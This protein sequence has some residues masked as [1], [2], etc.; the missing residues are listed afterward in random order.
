MNHLDS[1]NFE[2]R[3]MSKEELDVAVQWAANEGWNPGL[4]DADSFYA[5]DPNGY[6]MGFL[7]GLPITCISAVAYDEAFGFIGFYITKPEFRGKGYGV[8]TWNKAIEYLRTQNIGLDGVFAQQE[9]YKKSGFKLAY[10]NIRYKHIAEPTFTAEEKNL[11]N[12]STVPFNDLVSYDNE[13]FPTSRPQFLKSWLAM[14]D[15]YGLASVSNNKITGYGVIRKCRQGY[16]IG[17]LFADNS[18]VAEVLYRSLC[19]RI[20]KGA[21]VFFDVPEVNEEAVNL[22]KKNG[23]VEVFGTARMYTKLQPK[24]TLNKIYGV[25]TFELG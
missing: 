15:S 10:R 14:A 18:S 13:C 8:R 22:A 9:N 20:E 7:N 1:N 2:I 17:P 23:M 16:K 3:K 11:L 25:T 19:N 24:T 21:E 12:L 6:F 4:H 5:T